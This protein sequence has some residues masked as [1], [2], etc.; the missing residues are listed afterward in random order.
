ML[1]A[2][3]QNSIRGNTLSGFIALFALRLVKVAA[4]V[5]ADSFLKLGEWKKRLQ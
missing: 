5:K 1:S 4:V 3:Y 2:G